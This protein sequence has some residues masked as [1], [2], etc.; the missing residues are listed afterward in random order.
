MSG[1]AGSS[2]GHR[3]EVFYKKVRVGA[4]IYRDP[5]GILIDET[6]LEMQN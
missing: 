4:T 5:W 1:L 3:F 2:T 6:V